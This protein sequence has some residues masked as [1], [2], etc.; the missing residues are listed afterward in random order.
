M[1]RYELRKQPRVIRTLST[2]STLSINHPSIYTYSRTHLRSFFCIQEVD[3]MITHL[4]RINIR[5]GHTSNDP[6]LSGQTRRWPVL[7]CAPPPR[8]PPAAVHHPPHPSALFA[9]LFATVRTRVPDA[10][11]RP[12]QGLGPVCPRSDWKFSA[13]AKLFHF[14]ANLS[15][16]ICK[17]TVFCFAAKV[18]PTSSYL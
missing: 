17:L 4:Y 11:L 9:Q 1:A 8:L 3:V 15:E 2:S 12:S 6:R 10:R 7:T 16:M 18:K 13:K 14:A 5:P